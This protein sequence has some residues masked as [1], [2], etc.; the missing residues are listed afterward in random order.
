MTQITKPLLIL[1]LILVATAGGLAAILHNPPAWNVDVGAPG[2]TRFVDG[3]YHYEINDETDFRWSSPDSRLIFYG[4]GAGPAALRLRVHSNAPSDNEVQQHLWLRRDGH[5]LASFDVAPGWRTY[6]LLLPEGAVTAPGF[7]AASLALTARAYHSDDEEDSRDLGVPL[8]RF[9]IEPLAPPTSPAVPIQRVLLLVWGL[10]V[11]AGVLWPLNRWL[12]PAH[13][14]ATAMQQLNTQVGGAAL[15]LLVWAWYRPA[16]LG[17]AWSYAPWVLAPLTLLVPLLL[18][19]HRAIARRR[20][21]EPPGHRQHRT[22]RLPQVSPRLGTYA[23]AALLLVAHAVLLSPLPVQWHETAAWFILGIPGALLLWALAPD[24]LERDPLTLTFLTI[25]GGVIVAPLLLYLLQAIPGPVPWWALLLV[26]DIVSIGGGYSLIRKPAPATSAT[27]PAARPPNQ[28]QT[29]LF[30]LILV[31]LVAG[32]FRFAYLG[33]AEFQ[34][35]EGQVMHMAARVLYG[36]D[37]ILMVHRKGPMEVLLPAAP[38]VLTGH[39]TEWGARL[40]FALAGM[41]CLIGCYLLA[42]RLFG[43]T[44]AALLTTLLLSLDG[45][46]LA[47]SR[48]V[49]YQNVVM[50][51]TIGGIWFCWQFYQGGTRRSLTLAALFA[52]V[53]LLGHYDGIFGLP[54]MAWLVLAGGWQRGWRTPRQWLRE[55]RAPLLTGSLTLFS[56]YLPFMLHEHFRR[57]IEYLFLMRIGERDVSGVTLNNL[58]GYYLLITFYNTVFQIETFA[59]MLVLAFLAWLF[60]Y[61]R[62]RPL[63]VGLSGLLLTG[64]LVMVFEPNWFQVGASFNWA[65]VAFALPIAGLVFSPA[66]PQPLRTTLL[67]F[68]FPFVAE[69]FLIAQPNTH[70]Y[71]MH[72]ATAL[73]LACFVVQ[74]AR[75]LHQRQ[76]AWLLSP[77]LVGGVALLL[78]T[79]PYIYL[80][81]IQQFPEYERGFPDYRPNLYLADYGDR[82]P[83]GGY[84]GFPH[85]D[86]WKVVGELYRQ[87][88]LQGTYDSNQKSLV[89]TWYVRDGQRGG[90]E[91]TMYY[92]AV[93]IKGYLFIPKYY[94]PYASVWIDGNRVLD[95]YSRE[96]LPDAPRTFH[97]EDYEAQF[98]A[99]PAPDL[100]IQRQLF[101]ID[102][103][104]EREPRQGWE[105]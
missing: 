69:S 44:A 56:F 7:S 31:L 63:G 100:P 88:V 28:T 94:N 79:L 30:L 72:P 75:W 93:R 54:A 91:R 95:I 83:R 6:C 96:P 4:A 105:N 70:F 2:D 49:Q 52:A 104:K 86:G 51:M 84:F 38:M 61:A 47:F 20:A 58:S 68:G 81:Y 21:A 3:F 102:P 46:M 89:T 35:D 17:W 41:G 39:S 82:R 11:L 64:S 73:L 10:L 76:A 24:E 19:A 23:L 32:F 101:E 22:T 9:A 16:L 15:L 99:Q 45:F 97:L 25:C 78:V 74:A 77:T 18:L 13:P 103:R 60:A 40:P 90:E 42:L 5:E 29:H 71:T 33:N 8:D 98:D 59:V 67:W 92:I 65:I 53:G 80:V 85:Q 48:I 36:D 26:C 50:L 87:G 62:P 57:T 43:S 37:D 1:L 14:T 66:T 34:G 27:R 55:L 12:E